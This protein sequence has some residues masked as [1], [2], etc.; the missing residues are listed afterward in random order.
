[1]QEDVIESVQ[2]ELSISDVE[3]GNIKSGKHSVIEALTIGNTIYGYLIACREDKLFDEND[4]KIL[5]SICNNLVSV[6]RQKEIMQEE[7]D[8]KYLKSS[9]IRKNLA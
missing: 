3:S 1:M 5:A 2:D 6:I 7:K 9:Q 4:E 8:K